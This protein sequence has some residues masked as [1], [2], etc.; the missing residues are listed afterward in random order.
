MGSIRRE[1]LDHMIILNNRHLFRIIGEYVAYFNRVRPH[2]GIGQR[3]PDPP[4]EADHLTRS[5]N[6]VV[7][8]AVLG[9]VHHNYRRVA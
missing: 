8:Y 6:S 9:G 4:A 5:A 3:I 7:G 2:Q 1:C